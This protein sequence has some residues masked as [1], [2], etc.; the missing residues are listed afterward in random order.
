MLTILRSGYGKVLKLFYENKLINLHLREIARRTNLH[1]PSVFRILKTLEKSNMLRVEKQGNIKKYYATKNKK[2]Y[3]LYQAFDIEK[4]EELE[5][6]RKKAIQVFLDALEE[7]PIFTIL[8]GSTAKNNYK[9]ESDIDILLVTNKKILLENAL[10]ETNSLTAKKISVFQITLKE[11]EKE[12]KLK[13]DKLIQSAIKT[14]YPLTS[15]IEYYE[16]TLK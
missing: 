6:N 4:Y 11:F 1:E 14:G 10:I 12:L 3:L 13:E 16:R 8:F 15:H 9:E 2:T 5:K 7:K